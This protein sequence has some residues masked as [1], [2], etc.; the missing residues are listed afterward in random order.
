MDELT[1]DHASAFDRL[2]GRT[3]GN[4]KH[5]K[6]PRAKNPPNFSKAGVIVLHMLENFGR[7]A[8]IEAGVFK[9]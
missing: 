4:G 1:I 6:S 9:R 7:C 2:Y 5:H 3:N 8:E